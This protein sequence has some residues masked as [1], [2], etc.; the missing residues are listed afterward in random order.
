MRIRDLIIES[1]PILA[2][3]RADPDASI[4]GQ[5]PLLEILLRTMSCFQPL[6]RYYCPLP[7][8]LMLNGI[9]TSQQK[10]YLAIQFRRCSRHSIHGP[11]NFIQQVICFYLWI[12]ASSFISK[13]DGILGKGNLVREAAESYVV[14]STTI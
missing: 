11:S 12:H 6:N 13:S 2:W 5:R 10:G 1:A 7:F 4:L 3:H 9:H 14:N 8:S